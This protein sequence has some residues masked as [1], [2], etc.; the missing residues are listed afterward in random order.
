MTIAVSIVEDDAPTRKLLASIID[1]EEGFRCV[2]LHADT[3]AALAALPGHHPDVVLVDINLPGL[4][5]VECVRHLKPRMQETQ[6]VMLT[7]YEDVN[8]IF[9]ALSA[10]ATGYLLKRSP[11]RDLLAAIREVSNGGSPMASNIARM[12]VQSFQS[13]ATP[14]TGADA[15]SARER[16]VLDLLAEGHLYKEIADVLALSTP[17]V[18]TYIRRI[19]EKLHVRSRSQAVAVYRKRPSPPV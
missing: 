18:C 13:R 17:T 1:K 2:S 7:A 5:G 11:A 3:E 19:Y 12:V 15:L 16:Q 6:F 8:H 10:G 4:S 14:A 9:D